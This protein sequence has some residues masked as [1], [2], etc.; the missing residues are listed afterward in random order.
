M[1]QLPFYGICSPS[2]G[3]PSRST[4]YEWNSSG[5]ISIR[6]GRFCRVSGHGAGGVIKEMIR[7]LSFSQQVRVAVPSRRRMP[8]NAVMLGRRENR[9]LDWGDL[10]AELSGTTAQF[11]HPGR[12]PCRP[13]ASV[14]EDMWS[15]VLAYQV[16][17]WGLPMTRPLSRLDVNSA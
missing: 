14:L 5:L 12:D 3:R 8:G 6:C 10:P 15:W 7:K 16:R 2:L 13:R 4:I 11:L 1:V 9:T 17:N